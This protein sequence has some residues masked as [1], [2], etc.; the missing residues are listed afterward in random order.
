MGW[1]GERGH[2]PTVGAF[3]IDVREESAKSDAQVARIAARQHGVISLTQLNAAG[4]GSNGITRRVRDRRLH[5]IHRGVYAVGHMGLSHHGR[6]MAAVLACGPGAV[7]SH[8]A[9]G[10][11]WG[12][13][14]APRQADVTVPGPL[15]ASAALGFAFTVQSPSYTAIAR[16]AM[17]S[18]SRSRRAPWTISIACYPARSS[19]PRSGRRST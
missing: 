11:L 4:I 15:D 3:L 12:M 6:W 17:P 9:A 16:F 14:A 7:L 10:A 13:V 2:T 5:R 18:R 19:R 8:R 1:V